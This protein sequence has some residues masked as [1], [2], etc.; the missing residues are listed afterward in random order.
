LIDRNIT[1]DPLAPATPV[2]DPKI[3][4][5]IDLIDGTLLNAKN[6]IGSHR[7]DAFVATRLRVRE[8]LKGEKPQFAC[9]IC[10]IPVYIVANPQ[11][12]FF[13]RHLVED[14]SCPAQT[15]GNLTEE[16]IRARKYHGLKESEAHKRIKGLIERGLRAD[17]AFID[18]TILQEKHWRSAHDPKRWRQP[19]VQ[20]VCGSQRLAFEAQLST[21]FLDVVVGRRLFYKSEGALLV[22]VFGSFLPEYRRMTTDDLLF[23]NNSNVLVVDEETTRISEEKGTF[24]LRCL[25]RRPFL[26][27]GEIRDSWHDQIVRFSELTRDVLGQRAYFFD[28][29]GEELRL[30]ETLDTKLRE[31]FFEFWQTTEPHF[32][33]R[34]ESA[35]PWNE[36][37]NKLAN[38]GL[39]CQIPQAVTAASGR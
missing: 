17:P 16:E 22:W 38:A 35:V 39:R 27:V 3:V 1:I 23:S 2:D 25:Y 36:L 21:T 33:N 34:V 9:P 4:E 20:A 15:R 8:A 6:F 14:G 7:Y 30:R 29:Q 10:S 11:K 31:E 37:K 18:T 24:H 19:D 13:F 28:Y 32:D 26:E 5:V 12:H